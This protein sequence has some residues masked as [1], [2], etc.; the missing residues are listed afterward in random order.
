[1]VE[2][3]LEGYIKDMFPDVTMVIERFKEHALKVIEPYT[4]QS[5]SRSN[6]RGECRWGKPNSRL[7]ESFIIFRENTIILYGDIGT[8]V[9]RQDGIDLAWLRGA[10]KDPNYLLSKLT[11]ERQKKY[12]GAKT[13]KYANE[14]IEEMAKGDLLKNEK[15]VIDNLRSECKMVDWEN[16]HDAYDFFSGVLEDSNPEESLR[17]TW[18]SAGGVWPW[19]VLY[20]FLIE[21]DRRITPP[22]A[23]EKPEKAPYA[24]QLERDM[25]HIHGQKEAPPAQDMTCPDCAGTGTSISMTCSTCTGSGRVTKGG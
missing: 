16:E 22:E 19:A 23:P 9:L 18:N 25:Q 6:P 1:M 5:L 20:T 3:E 10:I 14:C 12:D 21:L 17:Y 11:G 15:P 4:A 8:W 24:I 13:M 2:I 7:Y